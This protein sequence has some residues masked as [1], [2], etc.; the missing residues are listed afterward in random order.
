MKRKPVPSIMKPPPRSRMKPAPAPVLVT[1][2][3][4]RGNVPKPRRPNVVPD[5]DGNE[6][7]DLFKVFPDLPRPVRP[8]SRIP[9]RRLR[10]VRSR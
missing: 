6:L 9:L 5:I 10:R 8:T 2:A 1:K 4:P 3:P 7:R